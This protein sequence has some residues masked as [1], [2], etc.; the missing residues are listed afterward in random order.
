MS[1]QPQRASFESLRGEV[2]CS[3]LPVDEFAG[4][5]CKRGCDGAQGKGSAIKAKPRFS[6][7]GRG[8]KGT[9]GP[10]QVQ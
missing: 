2:R 4:L 8:C 9:T 1:W 10:S 5:G 6:F 3:P 7:M